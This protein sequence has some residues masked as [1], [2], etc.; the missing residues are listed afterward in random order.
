MRRS[1]RLSQEL[2]EALKEI[3]AAESRSVNG[4]IEHAVR[5]YIEQ[6]RQR[7]ETPVPPATQP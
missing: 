3:A 1:L 4:A 5:V 2:D 7:N 6:W